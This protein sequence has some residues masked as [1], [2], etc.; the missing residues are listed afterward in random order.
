MSDLYTG[1]LNTAP[2]RSA[3]FLLKRMYWLILIRQ[4]PAFQC[5]R[6][7]ALRPAVEFSHSGSFTKLLAEEATA[8][9]PKLQ[10]AGVAYHFMRLPGNKDRADVHASG[11]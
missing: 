3:L 9:L 10:P 4:H 8:L 7:L 5:D 2:R 6:E 11:A 1:G